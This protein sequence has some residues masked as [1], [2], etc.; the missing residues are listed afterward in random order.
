MVSAL[1]RM[2][3]RDVLHLKG[4]VFAAALVVACGIATLVATQGTYRSLVTAQAD[5]YR[6]Y[7]FADVFAHLKRA[8]AAVADYIRA[9]P[10]VATVE[11]RIVVQVSADVPGLA[12]PATLRLVSIPDDRPPSLN[13]LRLVRGRTIEPRSSKQ[14]LVSEAFANANNLAVG[15]TLGVLL[16]G[17]WENVAVVGIALSPEFVYEV[18][19]GTLFPDNKRYGVAW[20]GQDALAS[21]FSLQGAF[22]DVSLTLAAGA[23]QR[24]VVTALDRLL[25]PHGGLGAIGRDEQMS[26][27]FLADELGELEVMTTTI[28]TLFLA[29]SAFLLYTVLSRLVAIQRPQIGLLKAFGLTN[30]RL[31]VHYLGFALATVFS[32]LLLALPVGLALG[33]LFVRVYRNYFHFPRLEFGFD[34]S[35]FLLAATVSL[36]AGVLGAALAVRKVVELAPAESMRTEP[37]PLF[38]AGWLERSGVARRLPVSVRMIARNV[39][40]RPVKAS[41]SILGIACATGLMVVDGFTMDAAQHMMAVQFNHVQ[42][43]DATV[44]Y[45]EPLRLDAAGEL[46]RLDG[47]IQAEAFRAVPVT[48][49]HAHRSKRAELLGLVPGHELRQLLDAE[50]RP[51]RLPPK[52]I[53]LSAKLAQLLGVR[54]GDVVSMEVMEG[55]RSVREVQVAGT[56]DEMLGLGAYMDLPALAELL[57]EE[58]AGSGAY[59]RI[60][61][62]R[63]NEIFERLKRMPAVSGVAVRG[64]LQ[65]SLQDTL[66]RTFYFFSA[67]LILLSCTIVVGTVYNNAR[68]ALSERGNELASLAILGFTRREVGTMLLGEQALLL[69]VAV[70]VGLLVGY[71][72][73]AALVPAFDRDL[74]R[75]PLVIE[76]G[77]FIT[78]AVATLVAGALSGAVVAKRIQNLD[79]ITVLKTRE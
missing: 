1:N 29:V 11:T 20:M 54:P 49:R 3:L 22:N 72:L 55:A 45:N 34:A 78:P 62:D 67:I 12:E 28:P 16:H 31:G 19:S 57:R 25:A 50:L 48:L 10:G 77:S 8:P 40:R 75:L 41:L 6:S 33:T 38:R 70:P 60:Q 30:A 42:R 7:R 73:C 69:L 18:G 58:V 65:R 51:L 4:Q 17:R 47:V 44:H 2:L 5:Y 36:V 46:G 71:G 74:F 56:V 61:S 39:V 24:E 37:P 21:A 35:L 68:I 15:S 52:G 63:A 9:L 79:L 64:A 66:D 53:V 14:M 26:H 27:R 32:G 76:A 23:S 59:L 13:D 43:E